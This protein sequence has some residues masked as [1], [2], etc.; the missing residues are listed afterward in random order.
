VTLSAN[1]TYYIVSQ[2]TQGSDQWYDLNTSALTTTDAT[3][4]AAVYGAGSSYTPVS[5][6]AGHPYVPVDFEYAITGH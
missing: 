1:A 2:E 4:A 3:L 6:T 5:A